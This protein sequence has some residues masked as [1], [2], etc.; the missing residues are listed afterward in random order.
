MQKEAL[1]WKPKI[2]K[3]SYLSHIECVVRA[4]F[5]IKVPKVERGR[6]D[7][8]VLLA[9]LCNLGTRSGTLKQHL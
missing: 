4:T 9:V 6:R 8:P 2:E 1:I 5:C 7:I 3:L